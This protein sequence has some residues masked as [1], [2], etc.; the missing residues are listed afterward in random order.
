M[1]ADLAIRLGAPELQRSLGTKDAGEAR[2][3]C[4]AAT[5]WFRNLFDELRADVTIKRADFEVIARRYFTKQQGVIDGRE[6]KDGEHGHHELQWQLE[7]TRQRISDLEYELKLNQFSATTEAVGNRL[8]KALG[9]VADQGQGF[10][11]N[12]TRSDAWGERDREGI[13]RFD[14]SVVVKESAKRSNAGK[15]SG[16][17]QVASFV[18]IGVST[19]A[20]AGSEATS[21][22][23]QV[24]SPI[25]RPW[26]TFSPSIRSSSSGSG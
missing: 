4:L 19:E 18:N 14:V 22:T 17:L 26:R 2:R 6:I 25:C 3:R 11:R 9:V 16:S 7:L 23:E 24:R 13:Y 10:G 12:L 8:I 15:L 20:G 21:D 1:P 5:T